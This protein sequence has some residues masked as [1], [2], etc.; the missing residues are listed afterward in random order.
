MENLSVIIDFIQVISNAMGDALEIET[1]VVDKNLIRIAGTVS[2][3]VPEV[4]DNGII[5]TVIETGQYY[6][7]YDTKNDPYCITCSMRTKC[8]ETAFLHCPIFF[9]GEIVG[10]LG[11]MCMDDT[12]RQKL[13]TKFK[14]I[15]SFVRHMCD[16]ISLNSPNM[17]IIKKK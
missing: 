14:T 9:K 2:A 1:S 4:I 17:K 8:H 11:I 16:R 12:Q 10:A 6:F 15:F 5:K 13:L 3:K 7:T